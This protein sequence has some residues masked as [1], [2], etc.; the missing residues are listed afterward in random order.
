MGILALFV[1]RKFILQIR[2]H[3]HPVGLDVWF[4]VWLFVYYHTS[5]V[6]T[7]KAVARL[8]GC[9]VSPEPSLVSYAIS[10]KISWAGALEYRLATEFKK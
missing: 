8:R 2:M 10:T 9:A 3:G 6:R 4:L 5:G 1:L 7:A